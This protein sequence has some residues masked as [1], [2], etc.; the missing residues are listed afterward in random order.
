ML[1]SRS[2]VTA[3]RVLAGRK[4]AYSIRD[5]SIERHMAALGRTINGNHRKSV[6]IAAKLNSRPPGTKP[7][8]PG[9]WGPDAE[10]A[11]RISESTPSY[12]WARRKLGLGL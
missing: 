3:W 1:G 9:P 4:Q 8:S 10:G 7:D 5:G 12:A 2:C 6:I 11:G